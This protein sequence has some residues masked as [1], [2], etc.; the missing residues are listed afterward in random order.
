[1]PLAPAPP[2]PY[3]SLAK[4]TA[5]VR[6]ALGD[7]VQNIQPFNQ[8]TVNTDPTGKILSLQSGSLFTALF[9]GVRI[10][11]NNQPFSVATVTG[12]TSLVLNETAPQNL[13]NAA[14]SLV[15]PTGDIFADTQAYVLPTVNLAWRKLQKKLA[16]QGH[17]RMES[18]GDILA[19][20]I[21]ANLDPI[22]QQWINWSN[23]YDGANLLTPT[24]TPP[25]VV[26]PPDWI[27]PLRLW[28][29]QSVSGASVNNPNLNVLRPMHPA[30]NGLI[31][32]MKG[33]CNRYWDWRN[34][35]LYLPGSIV[36]MDLRARYSAYLPDLAYAG[37]SFEAVPVKIMNCADALAYYTAA[38]FV[39]PRGSA[40]GPDFD[41]KGDAAMSQITNSDAKLKQRA[42]YSRIPWGGRRRNR[43]RF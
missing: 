3:D 1:M 11:I 27:S 10:L 32:R 20:P 37:I 13:L 34:D 16:D 41:A 31:S 21:I 30:A 39:T 42:S 36:P 38:I 43:L 22:S 14:Y 29:R 25:G 2:L 28:E 24:T 6:V 8:G 9:A 18:E 40:L 7:F 26:L 35:A 23:F 5:L 19:L 12:P 4:V 33:S 17:P 15:I